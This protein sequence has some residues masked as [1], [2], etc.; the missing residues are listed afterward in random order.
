MVECL[1]DYLLSSTQTEA[2]IAILLTDLPHADL[3]L[4]LAKQLL[5][6]SNYYTIQR[7]SS[8][9]GEQRK[10]TGNWPISVHLENGR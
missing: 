7:L 6:Q 2:L 9:T 10:L 3:L 1:K 5:I 8:R 4:K